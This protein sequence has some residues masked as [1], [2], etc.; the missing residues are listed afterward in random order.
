MSDSI[1]FKPGSVRGAL[2]TRHVFNRDRYRILPI[3]QRNRTGPG[4]AFVGFTVQ[5][6]TIFIAAIATH[7]RYRNRI[8][9]ISIHATNLELR[10]RLISQPIGLAVTR[11][12]YR[13]K[14]DCRFIDNGID[15]KANLTVSTVTCHVSH[16]HSCSVTAI[17]QLIR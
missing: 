7:N 9:V 3:V 4:S 8:D 1:Y 12:R 14:F 10:L 16:R 17:L 6:P 2:I 13:R 15:S 5:C 11:I